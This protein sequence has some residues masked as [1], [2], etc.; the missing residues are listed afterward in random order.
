ME[1]SDV[2]EKD[3]SAKIEGNT[4]LQLSKSCLFTI[5]V[6]CLFSDECFQFLKRNYWGVI[7]DVITCKGDTLHFPVLVE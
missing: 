2:R 4:S 1:D 5:I 7:S 6:G 3:D